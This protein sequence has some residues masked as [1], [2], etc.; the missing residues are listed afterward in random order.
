MRDLEILLCVLYTIAFCWT[1]EGGEHV[2]MRTVGSIA[3]QSMRS[4]ILS[5]QAKL[6]K[7]HKLRNTQGDLRP[8]FCSFCSTIYNGGS[9]KE[10]GG[11][12]K[13]LSRPLLRP[14][15]V[16]CRALAALSL[17][18]SY[19][20]R[21]TACRGLLTTS[22]HGKPSIAL[23]PPVAE[24]PM[25]LASSEDM[26][27]LSLPPPSGCPR[28]YLPRSPSPSPATPVGRSSTAPG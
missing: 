11:N 17:P 19:L 10:R 8:Q 25:S 18:T 1:L 5:L 2:S 3:P 23:G 4:Q 26:P 12:T 16:R 7:E 21:S 9:G 20:V 22:R 14:C 24:S 28:S 15:A 27:L 6:T 13:D